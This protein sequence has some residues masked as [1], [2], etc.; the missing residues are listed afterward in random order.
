MP[1]TRWLRNAIRS[2]L[3]SNDRS[4]IGMMIGNT[5]ATQ[6]EIRAAIDRGLDKTGSASD[7]ERAEAVWEEIIDTMKKS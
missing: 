4:Q 3:S 6:K 7:D 1:N 2:A 5:L